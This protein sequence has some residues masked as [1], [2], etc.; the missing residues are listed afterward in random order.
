MA[1]VKWIKICT[2]IFDDEK[3]A[4][5]ESMPEADGII[6]VWFKLLCMA[7][8][9]NRQ[10]ELIWKIS[11]KG[12]IALTDD[13]LRVIFRNQQAPQFI[14]ILEENGF[15]KRNKNDIVVIP[16]WQDR[17]DRSS[18]RYRYW[19]EA[20]FKRDN[21]TCQGCGTKQKLQAHH[22]VSWGKCKNKKEM[23]Y[24]VEN[25]VTLCRKCHLEA[26]GGCWRG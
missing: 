26:H 12:N 17:H 10:G 25:G 14:K 1:K 22:I 8:L 21:Y 4:L 23:R 16:F 20:V 2:D 15:L 18:T 3:I 9:K 19:R 7:R 11:D 6:V 5:I 13:V 24:A